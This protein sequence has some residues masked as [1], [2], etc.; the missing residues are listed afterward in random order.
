MNENMRWAL[1]KDGKVINVVLW[2]GESQVDFGKEVKAISVPDASPV[3]AGY[4]WDEKS[5]T[6]PAP[7]APT[8]KEIDDE[9][10]RKSVANV[11]MQTA[12]INEATQKIVVW[13]TKLL[14][15]RKLSD[16]ETKS[17]NAWLDYIDSVNAI[18]SNT[19]DD[20]IWPERP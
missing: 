3:Q 15:G 18:Q 17:L 12:L 11:A 2:D 9:K 6:A 8:Q 16:A 10:A 1:V 5:F 19:S 7:P 14:I 13:Q 4:Q 20:I